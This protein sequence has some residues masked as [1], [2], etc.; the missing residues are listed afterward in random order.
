MSDKSDAV[1][2]FK[3]ICPP[4]DKN[5]LDRE[6]LEMCGFFVK[7]WLAKSAQQSVHPTVATV[8]AQKVNLDARNS[9]LRKPLGLRRKL[10]MFAY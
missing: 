3:I 5:S 8:A 1:D 7:G 2:A 10:K 4:K 9:G 6:W